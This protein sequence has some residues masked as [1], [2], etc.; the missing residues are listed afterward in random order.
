M[1]R[2]VI[3]FG[4]AGDSKAPDRLYVLCDDGTLW[5]ASVMDIFGN[6]KEA[7]WIQVITPPDPLTISEKDIVEVSPTCVPESG[8]PS[9]D[10]NSG[11][12]S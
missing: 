7:A 9:A 4:A 3:Q 10:L 6:Q 1:K 5:W 12:D 11:A 2:K 8:A